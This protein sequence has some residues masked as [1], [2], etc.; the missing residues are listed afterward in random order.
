[1]A[2]W[3]GFRADIGTV[4][5]PKIPIELPPCRLLKP[6]I[7]ESIVE[8]VKKNVE[9][10][11]REQTKKPAEYLKEYDKY[12]SLIDGKAEAEVTNVKDD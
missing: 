3:A 4:L 9:E 7:L 10:V 12:L 11:V 5:M 6:V 2:I 8:S 1:M